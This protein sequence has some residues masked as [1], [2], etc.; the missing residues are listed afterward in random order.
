MEGRMENGVENGTENETQSRRLKTRVGKAA[1]AVAVGVFLA[2]A[3][4][5]AG[6][7]AGV[8]VGFAAPR[9]MGLAA[10]MN[11]A[12]G[13]A[14]SAAGIGGAAGRAFMADMTYGAVRDMRSV[15]GGPGMA[16]ADDGKNF[17][18]RPAEVIAVENP[19]WDYYCAAGNGAQPLADPLILVKQ[20]EVQNQIT[21]TEQWFERNGLTSDMPGGIAP[22]QEARTMDGYTCRILPGSDGWEA[23]EIQVTDENSGRSFVLDFSGHQYAAV[24]RVRD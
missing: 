20:S 6:D 21:D 4:V 22:G 17:Q 9:S 19:S 3:G 8:E 13:R 7:G 2:G 24:C 11:G 16:E 18:V 15:S 14:F 10:G 23:C 12:A 5:G 1:A